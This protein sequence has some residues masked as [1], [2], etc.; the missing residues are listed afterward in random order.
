MTNPYDRNR[1]SNQRRRANLSER[2]IAQ[3]QRAAA[4]RAPYGRAPGRGGQGA[5]ASAYQAGASPNVTFEYDPAADAESSGDA[6]TKR[7]ANRAIIGFVGL[8]LLIVVGIGVLVLMPSGA[9]TSD[10]A[11]GGDAA[12]EAP[13]GLDFLDSWK[14]K[15]ANVAL[16]ASGVK[17]QIEGA[18]ESQRESIQQWTGLSDADFDAAVDSLAIEDWQIATL[19][20]DAVQTGSVSG[21]YQGID[22]TIITYDDPAYLT[23]QAYGQDITLRVP[24]GAQDYASLLGSVL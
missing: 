7:L 1:F 24:E 23:V 5:G 12:S 10:G 15:A 22:A 6:K 16:D 11:A 14:D 19:P 8:I 2:T 20:D 9:D 3:P 18:I 21:T 13:F 17:G 4:S